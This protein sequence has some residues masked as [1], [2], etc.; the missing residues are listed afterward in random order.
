MPSKML[1]CPFCGS[2]AVV[3]VPQKPG[4][5]FIIIG[6]GEPSMLCPN[7]SMVVY[8]EPDGTFDY[9]WWNR[10][11]VLVEEKITSTNSAMVQF[12]AEQL[13]GAAKEAG[14]H[15]Q[16]IDDLISVIGKQHQ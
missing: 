3:K 9:K 5:N 8:A 1:P 4:S 2:E 15:N 13:Y 10:R 16:D 7:P 6:C 14:L 12:T 11:A